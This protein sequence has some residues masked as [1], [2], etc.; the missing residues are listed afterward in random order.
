MGFDKM[1]Y[2]EVELAHR[3]VYHDNGLLKRAEISMLDE[4]T[5]T[6]C[7]DEAGSLL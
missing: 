2:G 7:F 3:Y 6:L 4:D 5:V 1:V